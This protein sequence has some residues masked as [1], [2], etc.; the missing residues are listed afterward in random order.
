MSEPILT[1]REILAWCDT[2][3]GDWQRLLAANPAILDL[4]CDIANTSTVAQ[5]LQHIVAVEL[6]YAQR[7]HAMPETEYEE[8]SFD[9]VEALYATHER[10]FVLYRQALEGET[11]WDTP[12]EFKTRSVGMLLASR[13]TTLFHAM[14]HSIRHYAQLGT[15]IREHGYKTDRPGDYLFMGTTRPTVP[16]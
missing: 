8:I 14:F 9:S 3:S 1:A 5:L 11:D 15:L 16:H 4:P 6:R 13:K 10:A 2:T 7:I 12:I